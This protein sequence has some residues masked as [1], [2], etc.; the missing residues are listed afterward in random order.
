MQHTVADDVQGGLYNT[1]VN[2]QLILIGIGV[3]WFL[4]ILLVVSIIVAVV[5]LVVA[6]VVSAPMFSGKWD[7]TNVETLVLQHPLIAI[8]IVLVIGIVLLPLM[9]VYSF[10]QAGR[11]GIFIDAEANARATPLA[12]TKQRWD[13]FD[14]SRW[15]AYGQRFWWRT[16]L[17]YNI[18]WGVYSL[19]V[20]AAVAA[21]A[22]A[23]W[24]L[25]DRGG[26]ILAGCAIGAAGGVLLLV[27]A[28]ITAMWT[29]AAII[30]CIRSDRG[31]VAASR[32]GARISR[33]HFGRLF[34]LQLLLIGISVAATVLLVIVYSVIGLIEII[35]GMVILLLPLQIAGSLVQSAF[36]A[37]LGNW[38]NA[39]FVS[40]VGEET[41]L[42][43]G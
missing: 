10:A 30:D 41:A 13:A 25:F 27:G 2:W 31:A 29:E 40:A 3:Q 36:G 9:L 32:R 23:I 21:A 19:I 7:E 39:A 6:G 1:L 26:A 11:C 14:F 15:A 16:F 20:I 28:L 17:I 18:T 33:T 37:V 22:V 4:G 24:F 35:P 34:T 5:P 12:S 43:K 8:Y 38:Y 42:V